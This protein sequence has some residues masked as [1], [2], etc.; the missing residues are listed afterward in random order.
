MMHPGLPGGKF[1]PKIEA[2]LAA[3]Y[4]I[5][6]DEFFLK[7]CIEKNPGISITAFEWF[8]EDP[9]FDTTMKLGDKA[10]EKEKGIAEQLFKQ[11]WASNGFLRVFRPFS[12]TPVFKPLCNDF[13]ATPEYKNGN[14]NHPGYKVCCEFYDYCSFYVQTWFFIVCGV[15]GLLLLVGIAGGVFFFYRKRKRMGK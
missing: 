5:P 1:P 8:S 9:T 2:A 10:P 14:K 3:C 11:G 13:F 12:P 4:S 6:P 7:K 15:V